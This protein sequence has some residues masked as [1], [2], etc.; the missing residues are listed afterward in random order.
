MITICIVRLLSIIGRL[1]PMTHPSD[2]F[3][4]GGGM[5]MYAISSRDL[6]EESIDSTNYESNYLWQHKILLLFYP[7]EHFV[8]PD[9]RSL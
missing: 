2:E 1:N 9:S 5:K 7:F 3:A 4:L 8:L 6:A